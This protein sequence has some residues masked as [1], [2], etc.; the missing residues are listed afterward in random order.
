MQRRK[1][2]HPYYAQSTE[3]LTQA[4][5]CVAAFAWICDRKFTEVYRSGRSRC[6]PRLIAAGTVR[7]AIEQEFLRGWGQRD[8][9]PHDFIS[10]RIFI[11]LQLS[12]L[13]ASRL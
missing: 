5:R 12:L 4:L 9:N 7:V 13:P 2:Q 8:L 10:Q 3:A 6:H 11:L 1:F